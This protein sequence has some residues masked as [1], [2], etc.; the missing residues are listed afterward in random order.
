MEKITVAFDGLKFEESSKEYALYLADKSNAFLVG[1]FLEDFTHHSYKL[2]DMVGSQGVSQ[3][4]VKQLM[5]A[6]KQTR[7]SSV[8]NF[9]ASCKAS[10]VR[11]AIHQ[12]KS[13]ALQELLRESIYSD[14]LIINSNET[15]SHFKEEI[16]TQFVQDLLVS[17][18]CPAL[19]VPRAYKPIERIIL[20]YDGEPSSVFAV[21][22]F[23][24]MLP[25]LKTLSTEVL[26]VNP[27]NVGA[28]LPDQHLI[29]EFITCHLP[30]ASFNI[31]SGDPRT[32]IVKY[33]KTQENSLVVLGAYRRNMV[34]R[35]FNE[36]LADTLLRE[37]ELPLFIAHNK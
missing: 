13:V 22:A 28:E 23:C 10:G 5:E 7:L 24:Y 11:Y 26:M 32:E 2:F 21:K 34:S 36:S 20:L 25:F 15:L 12:D 16:P 4:K 37:V 18:Q 3:E 30:N 17:V 27:N 31:Q 6:D 33:L 8:T 14:L 35:W 29:K 19:V 9:E 1:V